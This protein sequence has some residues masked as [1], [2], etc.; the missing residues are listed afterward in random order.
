M[1]K[2]TRHVTANIVLKSHRTLKRH[3]DAT[4]EHASFATTHVS[5]H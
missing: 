3:A 5:A 4:P 1:T 2:Q